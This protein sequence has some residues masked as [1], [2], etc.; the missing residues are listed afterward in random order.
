MGKRPASLAVNSI[1]TGAAPRGISLLTLN[2]LISMPCTPSA[3]R[4]ASLT[5]SP[6]VTSIS[7][8]SNA[9]RLATTSMTR[10]SWDC[11]EEPPRRR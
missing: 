1:M 11:A 2:F 7:A 10:G 8:G 6:T 4:T 3:D 9:K 5:R